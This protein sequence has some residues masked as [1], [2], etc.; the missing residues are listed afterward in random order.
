MGAPRWPLGLPTRLRPKRL[1]SSAS[2]SQ[3]WHVRD[4][5]A[6]ADRIVKLIVPAAGWSIDPACRIETEAR[7]LARLADVEGVILV[8]EAGR[9][10]DGT[11]WLAYDYVEGATLTDLAP[12]GAKEARTLGARAAKTL[13]AAH[14]RLVCHGDISP[15]NILVEE[16]GA[17]WIADF[18]VADLGGVGS[19]PTGLTPA[20]AAPERIR[21]VRPTAASDVWSLAVTL[22]W[23]IGPAACGSTAELLA[24]ATQQDPTRRPTAAAFAEL[25]DTHKE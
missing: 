16:S 24:R 9:S 15:S 6:G 3:V 18:G 19:S 1:L 5:E 22:R 2:T 8:R 11:A 7:A 23:A 13:A 21:G 12:V 4:G 25:L 20:F 10:E 17:V 14:G